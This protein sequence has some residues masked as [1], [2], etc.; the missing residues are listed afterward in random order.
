MARPQK[1]SQEEIFDPLGKV[2]PITCG[3]KLDVN[4]L[5]RKKL[6]WFD[7]ISDDL[8]KIWD[9]NFQLIKEIGIVRFNPAIMPVDAISLDIETL[10][11]VD[12]SENLECVVI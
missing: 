2:T 7:T 4:E 12:T 10:D 6:D 8:R 11:T 9:D 5:S 1:T 3:F